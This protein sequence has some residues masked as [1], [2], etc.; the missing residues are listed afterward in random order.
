MRMS[1]KIKN[2][3]SASDSGKSGTIG[4]GFAHCFATRSRRNGSIERFEPRSPT[5]NPMLPGQA[6]PERSQGGARGVCGFYDRDRPMVRSPSQ[7]PIGDP[8]RARLRQRTIIPRRGPPVQGHRPDPLP[9]HPGFSGP[10][11]HDNA[12]RALSVCLRT[13]RKGRLAP[14]LRGARPPSRP[15]LKT[16]RRQRFRIDVP[17]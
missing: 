15:R 17:T 9:D 10:A 2:E 5:F 1:S 7:I 3:R 16:N 6:D 4:P 11:T 14:R 12:I 13:V 8:N